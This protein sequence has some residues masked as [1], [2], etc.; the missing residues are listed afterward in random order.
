MTRKKS[1]GPD[2]RGYSL[3]EL[4]VSVLIMS[5]VVAMVVM[6]I[7]SSRKT[8]DIVGTEAQIR[9]EADVLKR[10]ISE[11]AVEAVDCNSFS[12]TGC[13]GIWIKAPNNEIS[14]PTTE[15]CYYFFLLEKD[16]RKV[17]YKKIKELGA[18]GK[19]NPLLTGGVTDAGI[20]GGSFSFENLLGTS[21]ADSKLYGDKYALLA[22]HLTKLNCTISSAG[23]ITVNM[24]LKLN[25]ENEFVTKL[26]LAARNAG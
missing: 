22:E 25:D 19:I 14:G 21:A 10:F 5:V 17:R 26:N 18:D 9:G 2:N 23:L 8:Y 13:E 6:F 20:F 3:V 12:Y 24:T 4:I 1:F 16:S 11:L 7:S 15:Y